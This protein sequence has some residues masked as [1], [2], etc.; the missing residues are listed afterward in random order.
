MSAPAPAER[1]PEMPQRPPAIS[2]SQA[3]QKCGYALGF[4]RE[5]AT[6]GPPNAALLV[7]RAVHAGIQFH[8][9][10]GDT[11]QAVN[12]DGEL[13]PVDP[14]QRAVEVALLE[15][16]TEV[17]REGG[18]GV[19]RWDEPHRLTRA[20]EVYR[21]DRG[22]I[23]SY[24]FGLQVV[25]LEVMAWCER[26]P[27]LRAT[28]FERPFRVDIGNGWACSGRLDVETDVL[29]VDAWEVARVRPGPDAPEVLSCVL[30]L[31]TAADP[32]DVEGKELEKLEQAVLYQYA[33][34]LEDGRPPDL[35]A[36]HVIPHTGLQLRTLTFEATN[37]VDVMA[38]GFDAS[39]IQVIPVEYDEEVIERVLEHRLAP[40][41]RAIEADALVPNTSGW[42]HS[43]KFCDYWEA[44]P[45]G[46][47][48]R[49]RTT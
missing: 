40:T 10:F 9:A 5:R 31:K 43:E 4:Y 48:A 49:R 27:G 12:E 24:E 16:E 32:W 34:V 8:L 22:R 35:F 47:A 11:T 17:E 29:A 18:Q 42:W 1:I 37:D 44:C 15:F 46:A 33:R 3:T 26:F 19:V 2:Y 20:G 38:D 6:K 7:G 39:A 13:V 21:S 36:Y 25:G 41:I 30:D 45:L 23:P 28:S 14:A